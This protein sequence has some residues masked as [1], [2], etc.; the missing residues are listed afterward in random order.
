MAKDSDFELY[1]D[2]FGI[3]DEV[4]KK[5]LGG[6]NMHMAY[7]GVLQRS[8]RFLLR[9]MPP[10]MFPSENTRS[11]LD[12]LQDK[13]D[14]ATGNEKT[15]YGIVMEN[16]TVIGDLL[17]ICA[18]NFYKS[19][20]LRDGYFATRSIGSRPLEEK[21]FRQF[22]KWQRLQDGLV[23]AEVYFP[24]F[25]RHYRNDE[26]P[27]LH[28]LWGF[29]L[30]G[31]S[32]EYIE[33]DW[34]YLKSKI[35]RGR[36][37]SPAGT[38][39]TLMDSIS[40]PE[41]SCIGLNQGLC[42]VDIALARRIGL[43]NAE[44]EEETTQAYKDLAKITEAN[45]LPLSDTIPAIDP[46][47]LLGE[48][49]ALTILKRSILGHDLV[50][51]TWETLNRLARRAYGFEVVY[52]DGTRFSPNQVIRGNS[53]PQVSPFATSVAEV[54]A[55]MHG[56]TDGSY[57]DERL[58]QLNDSNWREFREADDKAFAE[59]MDPFREWHIWNAHILQEYR[60]ADLYLSMQK[61]A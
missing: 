1:P 11:I 40:F 34:R 29:Q 42:A 50:A 43:A 56:L 12:D 17:F 15:A 14:H 33:N 19:M 61:M 16:I 6:R 36:Y 25:I 3:L 44:Q 51:N 10:V 54:V 60:E 30:D 7:N 53:K 24:G 23:P 20:W 52:A 45:F 31:N 57:R 18:N 28:F 55:Q 41:G 5:I 39:R 22:S 9:K 32:Q 46:L 59:A 27:L 35:V 26:S 4:S 49:F 21:V 47:S 37:I 2:R 38:R 13:Y 8:S 58:A 48:Y